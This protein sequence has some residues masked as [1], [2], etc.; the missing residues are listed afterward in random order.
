MDLKKYLDSD[1]FAEVKNKSFGDAYE[2]HLHKQDEQEY[3]Y[4][5]DPRIQEGK[6]TAALSVYFIK[7]LVIIGFKMVFYGLTFLF[8]LFLISAIFT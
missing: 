5:P 6:D 4:Q 2:S 3:R 7:H 8:V 1:P